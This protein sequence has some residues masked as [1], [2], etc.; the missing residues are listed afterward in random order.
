MVKLSLRIGLDRGSGN[1]GK[2]C[3]VFLFIEN[4]E[5][6]FPDVKFSK[7]KL[8]LTDSYVNRWINHVLM[9]R[10][11]GGRDFVIQRALRL[12]IIK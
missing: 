12:A 6:R 4:P 5:T 11:I 7:L 10:K 3:E 8:I 9:I 1:R 2:R